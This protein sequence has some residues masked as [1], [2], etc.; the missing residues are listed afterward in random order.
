MRIA[1]IG[2]AGRMG[3]W[4]TKHLTSLGHS[5]IVADLRSNQTDVF[6]SMSEV[7]IAGCNVE[8]VKDA[9]LVIISVPLEKNIEVINEVVYHM[10]P[11]SV[12]CDISSVK[13]MTPLV[14]RESVTHGINPLCIHPMFGPAAG[15]G[16]KKIVFLPLVESTKEL[17]LVYQLFPE[18]NIITTTPEDHDRAMA[19]TLSL[20]YFVN[21]VLASVLADDDL[22]LLEQL[23]GTTFAVQLLLTGSVMSNSP[24]LHR[25][26]HVMNSH[27]LDILKKFERSFQQSLATLIRDAGEFE[28]S[29]KA[30]QDDLEVSF[31]PQQKYNMMYRL[32]EIL[33]RTSS[34]R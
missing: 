4:L 7:V 2:G 15:S 17:E 14:L 8:A 22:A 1:V 16:Q 13:G 3:V 30:L 24:G 28:S 19:L 5:L 6:G 31:N 29:Y 32:L 9:D 20:P 18:C 11:G 26:L 27:S 33:N 10:R 23:G 25:G 12:L 21:M 34:R